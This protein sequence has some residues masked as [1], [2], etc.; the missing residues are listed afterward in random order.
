MGMIE[1]EWITA[2]SPDTDAEARAIL[3]AAEDYDREQG[4]SVVDY[5]AMVNDLAD[6]NSPNRI[7]LVHYIPSDQAE[8]ENE[9]VE[10][11]LAAVL[12]A[13]L[14]DDGRARVSYTVNPDLRS[15]GVTT[16]LVEE[17][18]LPGRNGNAW[19]AAGIREITTWARGN[20]P[21]A[22][23]LTNRFEIPST[24]EVWRLFR[25]LK[26]EDRRLPDHGFSFRVADTVTP[27]VESY[28]AKVENTQR[29]APGLVQAITR[30]DR[31]VLLAEDSAGTVVGAASIDTRT[32]DDLFIGKWADI[33]FTSTDPDA[34]ERLILWLLDAVIKEARNQ[35][36][37]TLVL[38]VEPEDEDLV[39]AVR[40]LGFVH[41]RTDVAY[42]I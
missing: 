17:M 37:D 34:D 15:L 20:H 18:G 14:A 31:H 7:M 9:D 38:H 6:P 39:H 11:T 40:L 16:L 26:D 13:E 12:R 23:R 24:Q 3:E 30:D 32:T 41:E 35:P 27:A 1:R 36:M 28:A 2:L 8:R 25:E 33:D 5:R 4:F 42:Q 21:A 22:G 29:P 19:A 10:R